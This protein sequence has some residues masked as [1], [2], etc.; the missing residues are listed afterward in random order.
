MI[1]ITSLTFA[2][3]TISERAT[4]MSK[5]P[6]A[7]LFDLGNVLVNIHFDR[8]FES[9]AKAS[10][11]APEQIKNRFTQDQAYQ[12]H[13]T[14]D[15]SAEQY[16]RHICSTL[17][18]D[19]PYAEFKSGWN[20][21]LGDPIPETMKLVQDLQNHYRLFV[22]SNSNVLH[23][24]VW[25]E[26]YKVMLSTFEKVFCSSQIK[27]RKPSAE[28]FAKVVQEIGLPKSEILFIDDLSENI[29]GAEK[30]GMPSVLFSDP[31]TTTKELK[32]SLL[33]TKTF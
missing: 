2:K 9:W 12:A 5:L 10:G 3:V 1:P 31:A 14:G 6:K 20:A 21:V 32:K 30:F 29:A 26:R 19:I 33:G 15:I 25:A 27:A 28:A 11:K 18:I 13:E 7:V 24:S 4:F 17:E 22:F 8:C 16:H 23:R